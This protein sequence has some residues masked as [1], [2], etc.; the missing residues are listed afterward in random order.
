M[1]V[2]EHPHFVEARERLRAVLSNPTA[3][4]MIFLIGPTG[5][6][7]TTLRHAVFQN[8]V[9]SPLHWGQGRIPLI[10]VYAGLPSNAYFT[11]KG[12]AQT[13]VEELSYPSLRWM[14]GG[15]HREAVEV[16]EQ[17]VEKSRQLLDAQDLS[18]VPETRLWTTFASLARA[19]S[20]KTVS[21]EQ[22]AS[23][24]VVRGNKQP[25]D[26]ILHLMGLAEQLEL[27]FVLTGV[28]AMSQLWMSRPEIR[29]RAHVVWMRPYGIHDEDDRKH[30]VSLLRSIESDYPFERGVLRALIEEIFLETAG[31]VG[32]LIRLADDSL[33]RAQQ[34]GRSEITAS[35]IRASF[36]NDAAGQRM[37]ED[38]R[39][40]EEL[41]APGS[42][43]YLRKLIQPS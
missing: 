17:D 30:F 25:A 15:A 36:H 16:F 33:M 35:D 29:R 31:I 19:R 11:S 28:P 43:A 41:R 7:K 20:V 40:F 21:V 13:L 24:C 6:G 5:V 38:V 14:C 2:L 8:I 10:E 26:H 18:R 37:W 4:R 23:L 42:P 22:A 1:Q 34:G 27:N 39:M 32:E 3:G 12:F 9:G